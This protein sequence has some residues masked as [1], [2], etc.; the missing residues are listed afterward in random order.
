MNVRRNT[1]A[2]EWRVVFLLAHGGSWRVS[3]IA[4]RLGER[5]QCIDRILK[6]LVESGWPLRSSTDDTHKQTRWWSMDGAWT[7]PH[8]PARHSERTEAS[9]G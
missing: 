5:K 7:M 6:H 8:P 3:H 1:H 4:R 2:V 9:H